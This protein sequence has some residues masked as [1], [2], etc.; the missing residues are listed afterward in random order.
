[1]QKLYMIVLVGSRLFLDD[2]GPIAKKIRWTLCVEQ[3]CQQAESCSSIVINL[4][5]VVDRVVC[6]S[7]NNR[8]KSQDFLQLISKKPSALKSSE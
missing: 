1:M 5:S 7:E 6:R 2:L 8:F 4:C 3:K